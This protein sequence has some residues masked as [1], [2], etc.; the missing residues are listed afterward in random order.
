MALE[1]LYHDYTRTPGSLK[2]GMA[3][4]AV[5]AIV[6]VLDVAAG[7]VPA[8]IHEVNGDGSYTVAKHASYAVAPAPAPEAAADAG[9]DGGD[10][11]L[12]LASAAAY[13]EQVFAAAFAE[14]PA[15]AADA[16]RL[17]ADAAERCWAEHGLGAD[18]AIPVDAFRAWRGRGAR[19]PPR[20]RRAA[21]RARS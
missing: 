1:V 3:A 19:A 10:V 2:C 20:Q 14:D 13:L 17:G 4:H 7:W 6:E 12:G 18:D 9:E 15:R 8:R 11:E 5:G 16:P 21:R